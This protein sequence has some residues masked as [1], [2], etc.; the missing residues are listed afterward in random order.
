MKLPHTFN[1]TDTVHPFYWASHFGDSS[2][3]KHI[4]HTLGPKLG[5]SVL[6]Y[7]CSWKSTNIFC[8]YFFQGRGGGEEEEKAREKPCK[9]CGL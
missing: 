1:L 9:Q 3:K 2:H 4:S 8:T 6:H 7:I 5:G